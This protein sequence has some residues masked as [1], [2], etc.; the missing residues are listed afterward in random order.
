MAVFILILLLLAAIAGVLGTVLKIAFALILA[1]ILAVVVIGALFWWAVKRQMK[2]VV[3]GTGSSG[4]TRTW[5]GGKTYDTQGKVRPD[6][7]EPP[8]ELPG[9]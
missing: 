3:E 2:K 5:Y 4:T 1:T 8:R 7:D 6:Q 9:S